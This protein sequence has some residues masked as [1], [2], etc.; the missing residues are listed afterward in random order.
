MLSMPAALLLMALAFLST[1]VNSQHID[2]MSAKDV[3][4]L[5]VGNQ[6]RAGLEVTAATSKPVFEDDGAFAKTEAAL[7]AQLLKDGPKKDIEGGAVMASLLVAG[8]QNAPAYIY[9]GNGDNQHHMGVTAEGNFRIA[10]KT[11]PLLESDED[12]NIFAHTQ[13]LAAGS[14]ASADNMMVGEMRQWAL[15]LADDFTAGP[16]GWG[17]ACV[18]PCGETEQESKDRPCIEKP[19]VSGCGGV[20]MLGGPGKTR[21]GI[22]SKTFKLPKGHTEIRVSAVFH[23]IDQWEGETGFM[24]VGN[25]DE[26]QGCANLDYV[27]TEAYDQRLVSSAVSVCGADIGEGRFSVPVE[28]V[29]PHTEESVVVTLG[30]TLGK[31]KVGQFDTGIQ[32]SWGMS[33]FEIY[34]R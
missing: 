21:N 20:R 24:Q 30:S 12:G 13:L 33:S 19:D 29:I 27:W 26:E 16:S 14:I 34:V 2:T 22:V 25:A 6:L 9:L 17:T 8:K 23:F 32:A 10:S 31:Q 28:V 5:G 18:T 15:H 4:G 11:G 7:R 3:Q 1:A